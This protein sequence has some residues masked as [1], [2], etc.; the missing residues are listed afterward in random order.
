MNNISNP[1]KSQPT[2]LVSLFVVVTSIL[3]AVFIY[4]KFFSSG[5]I[6]FSPAML[7]VGVAIPAGIFGC[8]FLQFR[9]TQRTTHAAQ[10]VHSRIVELETASR[11]GDDPR[12]APKPNLDRPLPEKDPF[13]NL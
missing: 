10:N 4:Q 9:A 1:F 11:V 3:C 5:V 13:E 7:W 12:R 6:D 2:P 8:I